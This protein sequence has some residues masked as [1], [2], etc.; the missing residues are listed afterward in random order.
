MQFIPTVNYIEVSLYEGLNQLELRNTDKLFSDGLDQNE[1]IYFDINK[2]FCYEDGY[3]IGR[4]YDQTLDVLH[5]LKWC[6]SHNFYIKRG[7]K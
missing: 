6:F 3:S 2:G 5:S 1:Y 7:G 4:T